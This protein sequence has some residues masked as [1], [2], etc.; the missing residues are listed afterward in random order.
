MV[1][2]ILTVM[3]QVVELFLMI[4]VGVVCSRV[5]MITRRGAAQLTSFLL[6]LVA[7]TL[8]LVSLTGTDTDIGPEDL[9]MAFGLALLAHG[10]GILVSCGVF[11]YGFY[12][13]SP[14]AGG[15]GTGRR[16]LCLYFCGGV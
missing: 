5:G 9:A 15:S 1:T 8:I 6:Y 7:P 3:E 10:L 16:D 4:G 11:Q 12:G 2:S 13:N 14:G